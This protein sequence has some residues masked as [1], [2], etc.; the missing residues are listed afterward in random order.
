MLKDQVK[1]LIK[2]NHKDHQMV[3]DQQVCRQ[4][5]LQDQQNTILLELDQRGQLVNLDQ[6][7]QDQAQ[8]DVNKSNK[9]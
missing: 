8:T 7:H 4:V 5:V 9:I 3:K 2:N 1:D 6:D